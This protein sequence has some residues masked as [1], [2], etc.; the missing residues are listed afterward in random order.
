MHSGVRLYNAQHWTNLAVLDS[1][2]YSTWMGAFFRFNFRFN[3]LPHCSC[4]AK[5]KK[6]KAPSEHRRTESAPKKSKL[7]FEYRG[8]TLFFPLVQSIFRGELL[9]RNQRRLRCKYEKGLLKKTKNQKKLGKVTRI[10][11]H[12]V[13]NSSRSRSA[14]THTH[15]TT[16]PRS[17]AFLRGS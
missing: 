12:S 17:H 4:F 10:V 9:P 11:C 5:K 1:T 16:P 2:A 13:W 3:F 15:V 8:K 14:P 7:S 6:C